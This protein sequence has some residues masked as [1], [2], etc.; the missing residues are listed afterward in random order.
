MWCIQA[1]TP[2]Y[3][4]R[5]YR[6]LDL[7]KADHD[8]GYPVVCL[9]EKSKQLLQDARAPLAAGPGKPQKY[10]YEYKRKGTCNVFVAVA[11]QEGRRVVKVTDRRAKEDFAHFVADLVEVHFAQATRI[12]LV[13]D[14]LNTHFAGSLIETFGESKAQQLLKKVEFIHTPVHASWLNMAEI[15]IGVMDRQ[16]TGGRIASKQEL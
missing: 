6:L 15:E 2:E 16:C 5:M 14:N 7:Y 8:P 4:K 12:Q 13:L 1:L 3:R 11:P 10:D 9:D